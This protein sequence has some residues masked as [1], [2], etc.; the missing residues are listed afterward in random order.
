MV[1]LLYASAATR[2]YGSLLR[3]RCGALPLR[4]RSGVG[5]SGR[6]ARGCDDETRNDS[7]GESSSESLLRVSRRRR[8]PRRAA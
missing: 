1:S 2:R 7:V 3:L 8:D 6:V 5:V 4:P